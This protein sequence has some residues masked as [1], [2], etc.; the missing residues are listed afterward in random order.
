VA[1]VGRGR[2]RRVAGPFYE[3]PEA[4]RGCLAC[5]AVCPTGVITWSEAG[6]R[7]RIWERDFDLLACASCRTP[8]VTFEEWARLGGDSPVLCPACRRKESAAGL[9]AGLGWAST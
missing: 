2:N 9:K 3:P 6:G 7:R 4:C 5:A 8:F 1:L